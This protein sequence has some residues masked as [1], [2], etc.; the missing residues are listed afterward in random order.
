[1]LSPSAKDGDRELPFR[2]KYNVLEAQFLLGGKLKWNFDTWLVQVYGLKAK[3]LNKKELALAKKE[4]DEEYPPNGEG[5]M[6]LKTYPFKKH[7]DSKK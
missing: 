7:L 6:K 4:Y 1:M 5:N 2:S 3:N